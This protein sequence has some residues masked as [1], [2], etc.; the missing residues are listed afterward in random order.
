[1][2]G[3]WETET[4]SK[5]LRVAL[6]VTLAA[7]GLW[8]FI[9][10]MA[11]E[12]GGE[13]W[14]NAPL[15]RISSPISGTVTAALPAPGA[16]LA[17]PVAPV[18]VRAR[19]LETDALGA[20]RDERAALEAGLALATRQLEEIATADARLRNRAGRFETA[21]VAR[22]VSTTEAARA[23]AEACTAEAREAR[24]Q[25][26]RIETLAARGFATHATRDQA[27]ARDTATASRCAALVARLAASDGETRAARAG[28]YLGASA[29]DTPYAEQ[30]RDRLMLR[31]Q[32][33]EVV[34][35][36]ARAHLRE[37]GRRIAAE[38]ARLKAAAAYR[39]QLPGQQ[40]VWRTLVSTGQSVAAGDALLE[41]A[42]CGHRFV[43]VTL[44]ERR[45]EAM[46]P[47]AVARV[48]LIGSDDWLEGR[49][50]GV[51][52]A[53]ARRD[54]ALTAAD[55]TSRDARALT[56]AIAMPATPGSGG[57]RRCD[58]GRLAEVRFSRWQG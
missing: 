58:I 54:A 29:Q 31:R 17:T 43:E 19:A 42:D 49:I 16:H 30:Q 35:T 50:M 5:R 48:R 20:L 52:G 25:R 8:A 47:G 23:D 10:Y 9:P 22:L 56:V 45:M 2:A 26:D 44:P 13:A 38:E 33:L 12:V 37:L 21:A 11:N 14:V 15:T 4:R 51:T 53:A 6:A 40:I 34:A 41:L 46:Q 57:A 24:L 36:H 55:D 27:R 39:A 28:M 7:T 18:L 32:E 1:M 3:G